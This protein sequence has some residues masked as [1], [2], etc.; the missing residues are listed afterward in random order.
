MS[1]RKVFT[2]DVCG[3]E[4]TVE[5]GSAPAEENTLLFR[6]GHFIREH[7]G[8]CAGC[9]ERLAARTLVQV[10]RESLARD[11]CL[12]CNHSRAFHDGRCRAVDGAYRC[13]CVAFVGER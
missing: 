6:P 9:S 13:T 8:L 1:W 5:P 7:L 12:T 3:A 2:C 10:L 4:E 11:R